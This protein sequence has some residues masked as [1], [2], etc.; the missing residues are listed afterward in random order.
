MMMQLIEFTVNQATIIAMALPIVAVC[1]FILI[2]PSLKKG[3][4]SKL[5]R[6][7]SYL[8]KP[9][10][11]G[12]LESPSKEGDVESRSSA[13]WREVKVRLFFVYLAIALFL[14]SFMISEFYQVMFDLFL[15]VTQGSTGAI[16]TVTSIVFTSPFEFGWIGAMPWYGQLPAPAGL[17]TYHTSWSWIFTTAA[18]TDNP[19][20]LNT[21]VI[22]ML[23]ISIIVGFVF[24]APLA[25]RTIRHSFLPSMFFFLTGMMVFTKV[26]VSSISQA[27]SLALGGQVKYGIMT[28]SGDMIPNLVQGIA[29]GFPIVLAMF[30]LFVGFGWKLWKVHYGDSVSRKWFIVYI[31]MSF[32]LGLAIPI[33]IA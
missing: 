6:Y 3:S 7:L 31:T 10:R 20:F 5:R 23:L 21:M 9:P 4:S 28:V 8:V 26:A 13:L 16:R 30:C 14:V 18:F 24:L 11:I 27:I 15:P 17:G 29:I 22:V 33:V 1:L 19:D 32:W 25:S 12:S 2:I